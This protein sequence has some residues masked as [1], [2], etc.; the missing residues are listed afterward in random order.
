MSSESWAQSFIKYA[1]E[2][3]EQNGAQIA[4]CV[5][6]LSDQELWRR[7]NEHCNSIAN[8]LLHMRGNMHQWIVAGVGGEEFA[9]DR[10]AE[11][12]ARD[13]RGRRELLDSLLDTLTRARH[14]I[15]AQSTDSLAIPRNI[16]GYEVTTLVAIFHVVEHNSFHTG[17][18]VHMT[19]VLRDV[20]LSLYDAQGKKIAAGKPS[21]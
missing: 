14:I 2:K 9:R 17:Q 12:A 3:L 4:R 15:A 18:I 7:A 20:D 11:F 8:L 21:P 10:P 16:Q 6:L 19:K 5:D 13:G 1:G